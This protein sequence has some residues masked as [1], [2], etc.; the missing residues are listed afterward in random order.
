MDAPELHALRRIVEEA[1]ALQDHE[2]ERLQL[3]RYQ[4]G[5]WEEL[6]ALGVVAHQSERWAQVGGGAAHP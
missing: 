2:S 1:R 5:L 4:A 3:N 6:V